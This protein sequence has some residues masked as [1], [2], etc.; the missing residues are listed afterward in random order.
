MTT[1]AFEMVIPFT[2]FYES[3][4]RSNMYHAVESLAEALQED[5]TPSIELDTVIELIDKHTDNKQYEREVAKAYVGLV[6][7]LLREDVLPHKRSSIITFNQLISPREYNFTTDR[8]IV[9]IGKTDALNLYKLVKNT[10]VLVDMAAKMFTSRDGFN[11]YYSPDIKTWGS[12]ESFDHNQMECVLNAVLSQELGEDYED[13]KVFYFSEELATNEVYTTTL[14][15]CVEL[16]KVCFELGK[17][18]GKK[19]DDPPTCVNFPPKRE[20]TTAEYIE[21]F[22]NLNKTAYAAFTTTK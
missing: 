12:F 18:V 4:H 17:L 9:N 15:Q 3:M 16:N 5:L 11:S 21:A 1:K 8:I 2:G 19:S 10:P 6:D 7:K 22:T 13:T 14:T 20:Y